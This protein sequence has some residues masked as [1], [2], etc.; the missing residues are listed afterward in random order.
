M[1]TGL[2]QSELQYVKNLFCL[3]I[4]IVTST[5][6]APSLSSVPFAVTTDPPVCQWVDLTLLNL[7]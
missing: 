2:F 3:C 4:S 7:T 1:S 5:E 6:D